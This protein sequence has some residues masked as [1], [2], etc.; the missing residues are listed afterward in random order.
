MASIAWDVDASDGGQVLESPRPDPANRFFEF[1]PDVQDIGPRKPTLGDGIEHSFVF[2]TDYTAKFVIR[3]LAASQQALALALK[4]WLLRAGEVTVTTDD[5]NDAEYEALRLR[6]GTTPLISNEDDTR[7][8]F[9]FEC[10]L[11][12]DDPIVMDYSA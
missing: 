12:S 5:A 10:E 6:P 8:H 9:R 4:L 3:H 2:R 11:R 1:V 7:Q